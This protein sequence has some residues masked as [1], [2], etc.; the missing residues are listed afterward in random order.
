MAT[1]TTYPTTW[2]SVGAHSDE[3]ELYGEETA[4]TSAD[5]NGLLC[6]LAVA[7]SPDTLHVG[8]FGI[9]L[10]EY[11]VISAMNIGYSHKANVAGGRI[12]SIASYVGAELVATHTINN[13]VDGDNTFDNLA[14]SVSNPSATYD[15]TN[16][17]DADFKLVFTYDNTGEEVVT[18]SLDRV[19]IQAVYTVTSAP[20]VTAIDPDSA[21]TDDGVIQFTVTGTGFVDAPTSIKFTKSGE[22]DVESES[23]AI[24]FVSATS[25]TGELDTIGEMALGAWNVVVTNP[26]T[27]TGTLT[28][29]FTVLA[30]SLTKGRA[31]R[32]RRGFYSTR[33][34]R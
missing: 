18:V 16:L 17:N 3:W 29:G 5:A 1:S 21:E 30:P 27:Q 6:E 7:G 25:I 10:P 31:N 15:R 11:S 9:E 8:T 22:D 12:V 14:L 28:N 26:D 23:W 24:A 33:Y 4:L 13:A 32:T 34:T 20:T 2:T 19:Y